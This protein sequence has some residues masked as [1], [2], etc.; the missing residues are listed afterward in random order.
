MPPIY[1]D[2]NSTT[3]A[4]PE[5][6]EAMQPYWREQFGNPSSLH[7]LGQAARHAI[8]VA[9][10]HVA[11]LIGATPREIIFTSG[12]TEAD[13]LAILEIGRAHV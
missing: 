12:G 9:R 4:A 8:E 2:N 11:A 10:E 7:L 3:R 13:N 5:V 1:L 6:I